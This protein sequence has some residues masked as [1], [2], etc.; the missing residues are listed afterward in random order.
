[1]SDVT[2][3]TVSDISFKASVVATRPLLVVLG[4]GAS[5]FSH[6]AGVLILAEG[7]VVIVTGILIT[8]AS[9]FR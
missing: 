3:V 1:V 7:G 4:L 6:V 2:R 5:Y 9:H 8:A